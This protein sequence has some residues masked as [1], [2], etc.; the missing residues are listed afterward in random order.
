MTLHLP[1]RALATAAL[2]ALAVLSGPTGLAFA[3]PKDEAKAQCQSRGFVWDDEKGCADKRCVIG[4]ESVGHGYVWRTTNSN[5]TVTNWVCNGWTGEFDLQRTATPQS[6]AAPPRGGTA[7]QPA[8]TSSA[9]AVP[10]PTSNSAT[11]NTVQGSPV[12]V[13]VP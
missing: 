4:G 3:S 13:V 11:T 5:G 2:V 12:R 10:R 8:S 6:P 1:L 9:P 7:E